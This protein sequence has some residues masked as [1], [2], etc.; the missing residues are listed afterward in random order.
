MNISVYLFYNLTVDNLASFTLTYKSFVVFVYWFMRTFQTKFF[1]INSEYNKFWSKIHS[2]NCQLF[3]SFYRFQFTFMYL[4]K[5]IFL[6]E[7]IDSVA[8]IFHQ[9]FLS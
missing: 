1:D 4:E 3:E 9:N 5:L 7:L 6:Y 8:L 2:E